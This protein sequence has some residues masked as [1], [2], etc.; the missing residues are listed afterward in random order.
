MVDKCLRG[1]RDAGHS[2]ND[3]LTIIVRAQNPNEGFAVLYFANV[4]F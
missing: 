3:E 1:G 4:S 2:E